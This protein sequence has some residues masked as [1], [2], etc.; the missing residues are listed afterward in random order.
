MA[1]LCVN[2]NLYTPYTIIAASQLHFYYCYY[3]ENNITK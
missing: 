3:N 2:F 1:L